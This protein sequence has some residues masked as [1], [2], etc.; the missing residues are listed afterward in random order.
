MIDNTFRRY[1]N[2]CGELQIPLWDKN[3]PNA[4]DSNRAKSVVLSGEKH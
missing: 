3:N 1:V 2:V 4:N